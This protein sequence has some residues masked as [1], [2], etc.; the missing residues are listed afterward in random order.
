MDAMSDDDLGARGRK[1]LTEKL[2]NP[3]MS[4]QEK[5]RISEMDKAEEEERTR[6]ERYRSQEAGE[7]YGDYNPKKSPQNQ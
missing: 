6:P 4:S 7:D 5:K 3:L 1:W 2:G